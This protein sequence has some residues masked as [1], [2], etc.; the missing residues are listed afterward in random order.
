ME[1]KILAIL[2]GNSLEFG[3]KKNHFYLAGGLVFL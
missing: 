1:L 2:I 3:F